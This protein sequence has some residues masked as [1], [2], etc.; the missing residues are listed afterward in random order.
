MI[1]GIAL[2]AVGMK[3]T[4]AHVDESLRLIGAVAMLGGAAVYLFA[5]VAFRLRNMRTFNKQRLLVGAV[6]VL[7]I[8]AGVGLPS[9]ATLGLLAGVLVGLIAYETVR[10]AEARRRVRH[11]LATTPAP[12]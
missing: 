6:L 2:T 7:L 5:H 3:Q 9:L 8:P 11:D 10:F 1:A 12:D 4:L